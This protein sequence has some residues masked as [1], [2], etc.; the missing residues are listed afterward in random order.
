MISWLSEYSDVTSPPKLSKEQIKNIRRYTQLSKNIPSFKGL[1]Y[2]S[3]GV[4]TIE[5]ELGSIES[6]EED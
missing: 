4:G 5:D 3:G 2:S 6:S 1:Q